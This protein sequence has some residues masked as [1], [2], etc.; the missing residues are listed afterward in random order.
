[1]NNQWSRGFAEGIKK[2]IK[3]G[4]KLNKSPCSD[5]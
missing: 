3:V 2:V 5:V 1:M 4:K